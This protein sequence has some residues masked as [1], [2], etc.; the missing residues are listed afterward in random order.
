MDE[1]QVSFHWKDYADGHQN[2]LM[3]LSAEEFLRRFL[4]HVLSPWQ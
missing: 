2:K 1:N 3:C 4:L